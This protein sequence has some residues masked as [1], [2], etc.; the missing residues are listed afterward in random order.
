MGSASLDAAS[1]L[2]AAVEVVTA[3]LSVGARRLQAA[4]SL[5]ADSERERAAR[6]VNAADGERYIAGRA[7][8]RELLGERLQTAPERVELVYGL[9][10][11][12]MLAP[13]CRRRLNF[14]V[15]HCEDLVSFAFSWLHPVGIDIEPVRRIGEADSIVARFF[16][17]R[18]Q[19]A[20]YA[21]EPATR[22]LGFYNCW[23]RKEAFVK[24]LGDG[25][26]RPLHSFDVSLAPHEPARMLRIGSLFGTACGWSLHSFT[27]APGVVGAVALRR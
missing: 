3:R 2:G 21:L 12:P 23:T 11:K 1:A 10:G 27:P 19:Q 4:L 26:A 16:S 24:A 8:L 14:S 18:E 25:L 7:R 5:L 22:L 9:H 17:H 6:F 13:G 15:A 20:Y